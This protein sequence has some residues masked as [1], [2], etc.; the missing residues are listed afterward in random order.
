[1]KRLNRKEKKTI[2][3]LIK[4]GKSLNYISKLV[5]K[6]KS[7]LYYHYKNL[8][9]KKLKDLEID[10]KDD[11]FIG[12]LIGLFVGD[13]YCFFDKKKYVYSIRLYFNNTEKD[14]VNSIINL[15]YEKLNKKPHL[16]RVKNVLVL[17]YYSKELFNFILGYV[18]W[19]ISINRAGHNKKS[20]TVFLKDLPYSKEFKIGFLRGFVDT[21]GHISN[22]KI[23][24]ASASKKI[25]E[26]TNSFLTDLGFNDFNYFFYK[27]KRPNMVGMH[28][29]NLNKSER[30]KFF[31]IIQPRNLVKLKTASVGNRTRVSA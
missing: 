18:G 10:S 29:I 9:G 11:L 3:S 26:Q 31:S 1:M 21:D 23:N 7:T 4:K 6:N 22:K 25:M 20:R 17:R 12:E 5:N 15:F 30:D 19:G 27:E 2:S 13:G 16:N 28:H 8:F 14:Y 24:F